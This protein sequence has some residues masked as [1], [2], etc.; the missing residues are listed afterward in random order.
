MPGG[1]GYGKG[2]PRDVA[3]E[4][5]AYRD[6]TAHTLLTVVQKIALTCHRRSGA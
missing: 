6:L 1:L 5:S 3:L 4:A 2:V